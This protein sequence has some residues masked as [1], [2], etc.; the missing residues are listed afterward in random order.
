MDNRTKYLTYLRLVYNYS[1]NIITNIIINIG[2][3]QYNTFHKY[4]K[5]HFLQSYESII[6]TFSHWN[7]WFHS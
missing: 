5:D 6:S 3:N 1:L 7:S 2:S 4:H